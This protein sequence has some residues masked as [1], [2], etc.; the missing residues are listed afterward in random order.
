VIV[1]D[2]G[3]RGLEVN[4]WVQTSGGYRYRG[5]LVVPRRKLIIEYQSRFHEQPV[6]FRKDMTRISRLEADGWYVLQVNHNELDN[7][8]ELLQRINLVLSTRPLLP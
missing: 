5:D 3:I 6:D 1:G 2:G 4:F 8:E 7:P